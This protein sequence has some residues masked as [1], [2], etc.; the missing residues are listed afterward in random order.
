MTGVL[1]P[2]SVPDRLLIPNSSFD[3]AQEVSQ[4][5]REIFILY[6]LFSSSSHY[7][8]FGL[9]QYFYLMAFKTGLTV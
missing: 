8:S 9:K 1:D 4:M 2:S 3:H 7:L 6:V 5:L